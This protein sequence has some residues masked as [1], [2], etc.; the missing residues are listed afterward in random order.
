MEPD[1]G[2]A[3]C[4]RQNGYR[5]DENAPNLSALEARILGALV[6]K[7]LSTPEY[8]PPDPPRAGRRLQSEK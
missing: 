1:N 8:H 6:E 3:Q 2:Q 7:E 4:S 5:I